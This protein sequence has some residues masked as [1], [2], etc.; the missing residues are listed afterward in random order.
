MPASSIP[1]DHSSP[2][3]VEPRQGLLFRGTRTGE[4]VRAWVDPSTLHVRH[5]EWKELVCFMGEDGAAEYCAVAPCT[6]SW[7]WYRARDTP[8]GKYIEV[9]TWEAHFIS[10][11]R[12]SSDSQCV[13]IVADASHDAM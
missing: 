3:M 8:K 10:C 6:S 11:A 1:I 5:F 12:L 4:Y 7:R 2:A 13:H 9:L